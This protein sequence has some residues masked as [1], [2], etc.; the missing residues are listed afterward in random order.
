MKEEIVSWASM[1]MNI[2]ALF[3]LLGTHLSKLLSHQSVALEARRPHF[4]YYLLQLV[5][6]LLAEIY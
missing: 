1:D 3:V 2:N 4:I 6:S 5:D